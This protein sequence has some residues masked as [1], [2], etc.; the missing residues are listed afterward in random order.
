M[1]FNICS[2]DPSFENDKANIL[3]AGSCTS[4]LLVDDGTEFVVGTAFF[5]APSVLV[6]AGH[7]VANA[8]K[9]N[10]RLLVSLPGCPNVDLHKLQSAGTPAIKCSVK[11]SLRKSRRHTEHDIAILE[12]GYISPHYLEIS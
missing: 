1:S 5:V 4:V 2:A 3:R 6:T 7:V 11:A 12:C 9:P 8:M 10:V